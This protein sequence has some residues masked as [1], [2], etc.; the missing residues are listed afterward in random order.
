MGAKISKPTGR[1]LLEALRQRYRIASKPDKC[2][3]LDEFID[4][5]RCHRNHPIRLLTGDGPV[6]PG[7]TRPG[8]TIDS[9]AVRQALVV[10]W[11]AAHRICGKRLKAT[12]PGLISAMERHGHLALDSKVR[13]LLRDASPTTI[14]RLL[15]PIRGAA[16]RRR[17]R[18]ATTEASREIPVRT[19]AD[20]NQPVPGFLEI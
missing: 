6:M 8:R 12:L 14:D 13:Q 20:W 3:I 9:E 7:A 18:K 17:R 15:A 10:L 11:E 19:F 1:E 16:G 2:K 4:I 5:T